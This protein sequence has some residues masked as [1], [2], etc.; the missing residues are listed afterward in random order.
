G[1]YIS[2]RSAK[3]FERIR[4]SCFRETYV[5]LAGSR[6]KELKTAFIFKEVKMLN[7]ILSEPEFIIL[8]GIDYDAIIGVEVLQIMGLSI[9]MRADRLK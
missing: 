6:E 7:V 1:N 4:I 5:S 9:D 8:D 3:E 2:E